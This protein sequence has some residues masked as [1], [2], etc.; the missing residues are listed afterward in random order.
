MLE[1]AL[2]WVEWVQIDLQNQVALPAVESDIVKLHE[3][4]S[5]VQVYNQDNYVVI[6]LSED[7][8]VLFVVVQVNRVI[9]VVILVFVLGI[10]I[11]ILVKSL[12]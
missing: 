7:V 12:T 3:V 6:E 5:V 8:R 9:Q 11:L 2:I 1:Q 4:V 10:I